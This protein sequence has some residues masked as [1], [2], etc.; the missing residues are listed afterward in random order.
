MAQPGKRK[1][2][3]VEIIRQAAESWTV[4]ELLDCLPGPAA[5]LDAGLRVSLTNRAF[6]ARYQVE[7]QDLLGKAAADLHPPP[8]DSLAQLARRVF[9]N[10]QPWR[11]FASTLLPSEGHEPGDEDV[12]VV[13]IGAERDGAPHGVLLLGLDARD[14]LRLERSLRVGDRRYERQELLLS[15]IVEAA[16]AGIA[17]IDRDGVVRR[18]NAAFARMVSREVATLVDRTLSEVFPAAWQALIAQ[19]FELVAHR[20]ETY[21]RE[22]AVVPWVVGAET[23]WDIACVPLQDSED[24]PTGMVVVA[25]DV[26]ARAERE[27]LV[28]E[29][30]AR[31]RHL[32]KLKTDFLGAASHELRT[33]LSAILGYAELLAEG[34]VG[35]L[36][37]QQQAFACEIMRATERL[38]HLI[39]DLL[40]FAQLESGALV[41]QATEVEVC[42]LVQAAVAQARQV[43]SDLGITLDVA[44][45][46][47][48]VRVH[49]D[50][51]R[52]GRA[53]M[54]LIDNALKFTPRGG[55][56]GVRVERHGA[57]CVIAVRDSGIGIPKSHQPH[58]F[59][60]FYQVDSGST[61]RTGGTGIGLSLV[62]A[63]VEAHGGRVGVSSEPGKGSE[64]RIALPAA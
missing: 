8:D 42:G 30:L 40:D 1:T 28:D 44:V 27:R 62:R 33:P 39:D 22:S 23:Y 55:R 56:V 24:A 9:E 50:A 12:L 46:E 57:S 11:V 31:V 21:R 25:T 10:R 29:Q 13:P 41:V 17:F 48:P 18:A 19:V 16:P 34:V 2:T 37:P 32:E 26:T 35:E 20:G 4:A 5:C 63:I 7:P 58:V 49:G 15:R 47:P 53:V 14:R 51:R 54:H 61:R 45:V 43:A 6:A 60:K 52:L 64:F 3:H 36:G 38:H 59:D